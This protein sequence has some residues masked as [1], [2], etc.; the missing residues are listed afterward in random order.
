[1]RGV[2][3]HAAL[4]LSLLG[5]AS[6]MAADAARVAV[7]PG[8]RLPSGSGAS[9]YWD[10]AAH[11]DSGHRLYVRFLITNEGPGV[12]NGLV[13][14]HV[15]FPDGRVTPFQNGRRESRWSLASDGRRLEVGASTLDLTA[16]GQRHFD[17]VKQ[18]QGIRLHLAW[19]HADSDVALPLEVSAAYRI[20]LLELATPVR[21]TLW[22]AGMDAPDA[23]AGSA[24]LTH[25]W[26]HAIERRAIARRIDV[27]SFDATRAFYLADLI[28]PGGMRRQA[29][30]YAERGHDVTFSNGSVP[31]PDAASAEHDPNALP[32]TLR[33]DVPAATGL[34]S[35]GEPWLRHDPLDAL[36]LALR[37]M[38]FFGARPQRV[39]ADAKLKIAFS[40]D[41][42][43]TGETLRADG[44]A[45]LTFLDA[46][47]AH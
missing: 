5:L 29:L 15:I 36:P 31:W 46:L 47:P 18:R 19:A 43:R 12:H 4:A 20:D 14:G 13:F 38:Y 28:T 23:V 35:L 8:A 16:T 2:W 10:L 30:A 27:M 21:G 40:G 11:F 17:V 7:S 24:V 42:T 9:E 1:M 33:V 39:W 44:V 45:A 3:R 22:V 37:M 25:T 26:T 6:S 34:I 41:A 32:Q